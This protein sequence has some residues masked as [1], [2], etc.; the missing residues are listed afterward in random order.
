MPKGADMDDLKGVKTLILNQGSPEEL[1]NKVSKYFLQTFSIDEKLYESLADDSVFYMRA[2]PLRHPL[3]FY[4]GHT[5]VFYINKLN[6]AR[7]IS[8]RINAEFES[9]FAVGVDEMSWDDLNQAHYNWPPIPD[10]RAY[11]DKVRAFMLELINTLP[12]PQ[13][14]ITWDSPWWAIIMGIEHQRIHLETSSVLIRHLP[15]D[16]VRQ[17]EFWYICH[18]AGEAPENALLDVPGAE[19]DLGKSY[20]DPLYGWDNEYGRKSFVVKDFKASRYLVSNA[21]FM[22]FIKANG[23]N[24]Q[25]YWTEEGW[26]WRSYQQ[27]E[28]PRFWQKDASGN[29]M[30]RT[31]A[32]IVPMP[33]NHPVEVNYLEAKAFCNW[34]A[35]LTGKPIRLPTEA[36]W[37]RM[38]DLYMCCD[39]PVWDNAPGNINLEY[40]ASA[41]PVDKFC[42]GMFYDLIGNV[43]Q[44][45]ETPISAYPGFRV[46]PYYDDF[47]VPTF[48]TRHNLIKGGSFI[49]TGNEA[50]RDSRYAFRRHFYQHAG[51]R[52][53]E[54]DQPVE[55]EDNLYEDDAEIIPWCDLDWGINPL[56]KNYHEQLVEAILPY[57]AGKKVSTA[58]CM[59][60]KTGRIS[61]ELAKHC[62]KV[63]GLDFTARLI[64]L[65]TQVKETGFIRYYRRDEGELS[66]TE[67]HSL[68]EFGLAETAPRCEFWQADSANLAAKFTGYDLVVAENTLEHSN[69]PAGF[70]GMIHERLNPGGILVIADGYS[71][72][73]DA[74]RLGGFRKD[75]EP[76]S[77][78]E[79]IAEILKR[80]FVM[81]AEPIELLQPVRQ[82]ARM[83]KLAQTQVSI[84]KKL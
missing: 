59:G 30:L 35:A 72:L 40:Y 79:A 42:F 63:I 69:N 43:W 10:V 33:W 1:R 81:L 61:F 57:L 64:R 3:V 17:L 15:I 78:L 39:M 32:S 5:A 6:I 27:A 76:F 28:H 62:S 47:S 4:L 83:W 49:S 37:V 51:F 18:E 45:T 53:I 68:T 41:C 80:Q 58:L 46:H 38:R 14:G 67:E 82:N 23:Y 7:I 31:M 26:A 11:R 56:G 22:G 73:D 50:L 8:T 54:S 75:G 25:E 21:E 70:L 77:N 55:I 20:D 29:W 84:W 44:W 34:K 2:D 74:A 9:M 66:A 36:E 24:I 48:D 65:A 16:K 19:F 13:D 12:M 60:C 52:Y 71:W